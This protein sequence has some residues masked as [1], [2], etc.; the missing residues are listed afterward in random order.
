M[1]ASREFDS[2]VL[3]DLVG[4]IYEAAVEPARWQD[5]I[6]ALERF[7]PGARVTLFGHENGRLSDTLRFHRNFEAA[8]LHAY[9]EQY[10][11][12]SPYI[13]RG[14]KL[15]VG[16][17]AHYELMITDKELFQTDHYN[18]YVKPRRL[19]HYGTGVVVERNPRRATALSLAD[20]RNNPDR[21][22]RQRRLL[23]LLTP[24]MMRAFR[25]HRVVASQKVGGDAAQAAFDRWSHP[26]LVLSANCQVVAMNRS[27]ETLL[28]RGDGLSLGPDGQLLS[29]DESATRA[30]ATAA[31]ACA[32]IA[33]GIDPETKPGQIDAVL[34]PRPSGAAALRTMLA[35]V[36]FF[37]ASGTWEFGAGAVLLVLFDPEHHHGTSVDWIARQYGLTPAEARLTE[38]IVNGEPLAGAAERL[39]IQL[40]T[41]RTR[42]KT[43]QAKTQCF[44]QVDLVRLALAVPNL[45]QPR[46]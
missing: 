8:D 41:A 35:P 34:L 39:G 10:I 6:D 29:I 15:S 27:A 32:S 23:R 40:S 33:S 4:L 3:T 44:R 12:N 31:R 20:H 21:R 14:A 30:L 45:G 1:P 22:T 9:L 38:A 36:P 7:Y 46:R 13:A 42:L 19:G 18:D 24:H 25:L 17:P 26:A 16:Q 5:F 11:R 28:R 43:I 37:G 2:V